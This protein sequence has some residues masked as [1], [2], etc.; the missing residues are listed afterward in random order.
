MDGT[1]A[2]NRISSL[3]AWTVALAAVVVV[4]L[5]PFVSGLLGALVLFVLSAP[6]LRN[7]TSL[8]RRRTGAFLLMFLCFFALVLPGVWLLGELLAQ[9]PDAVHE[10]QGSPAIQRLMALHIGDIEVGV[11]LRQATAEIVAWSSRQTIAAIGGAM[12]SLL[13]LVV[14]LFGAYYL[15]TARTP[16][17]PVLRARLPVSAGRAEGLRVRFRHVTEAMVLGVLVAGVAQGTLVGLAFWALGFPHY[18]LWA[19]ATA[20]ASVLPIFGS[21]LVWLPGVGVL[22]MHD[23]PG[24]ALF[25]FLYGSVLVSNVDNAL[26]LL[27]YRRVSRI[28][29]MVTLVGA[30]AGVRIFGV[31]GLLLGPL[32]LCYATEL[33]Q[34]S[35][36]P[37][38]E[39][40]L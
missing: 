5:L 40:S 36:G 16:L 24:A 33:A 38:L 6:L 8:H 25:L 4:L 26:R 2:G 39:D 10:L 37:V 27:V 7:V 21:A 35:A 28:H 23:R 22:V 13:N 30:F 11:I 29:P 18:L 20:V 15:L 3:R 17:W 1:D 12:S 9:V 34:L 32:V 31:A 19:A 14:A